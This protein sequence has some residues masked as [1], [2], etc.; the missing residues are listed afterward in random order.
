MAM[1]KIYVTDWGEMTVVE[2][3][4]ET[5]NSVWVKGRKCAKETSWAA[6]LDNKEDAKLWAISKVD[7][8]VNQKR[9]ALEYYEKRRLEI[10]NKIEKWA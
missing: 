8:V 10:I 5:N 9:A 2:I 1:T 4:R 6:Y 3:E 7:G